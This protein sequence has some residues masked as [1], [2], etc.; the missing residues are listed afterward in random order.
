MCV[1]TRRDGD[2]GGGGLVTSCYRAWLPPARWHEAALSEWVRKEHPTL[3]GDIFVSAAAASPAR[4]VAERTSQQRL[5]A[6][7]ET[8][9]TPLE[10]ASSP[11]AAAPPPINSGLLKS[12]P[13]FGSR[14]NLKDPA[15]TKGEQRHLAATKIQA[16]QRG[17]QGRR[18]A[19]KAR[20]EMTGG[21]DR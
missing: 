15:L 10:D 3:S 14:R 2:G 1:V 17:K 11:S 5:G 7:A 20:D 18:K 8:Q 9:S 6:E 12:M 13:G 16:A 21:G 19:S 4:A